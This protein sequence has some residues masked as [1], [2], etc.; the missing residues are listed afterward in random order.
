VVIARSP[1]RTDSHPRAFQTGI[2]GVDDLVV[3]PPTVKSEAQK[4]GI[5]KSDFYG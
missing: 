4:T 5:P 3:N 1:M 2:N